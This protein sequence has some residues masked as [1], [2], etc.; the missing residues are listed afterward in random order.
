MVPPVPAAFSM[1]SQRSS[2][3]SS[4]SSRSAGSTT[5]TASSNPSPRWEPTW[6]TTASEPIASAVSIVARSAAS[7]FVAHDRVAAREIHEVEGV[8]GHAFTR[9]WRRLFRNRAISSGV[10]SV[11]RHIRGLWV[12]TWTAF[13]PISSTRSI[14]FEIP[15]AAET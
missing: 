6:K 13:P 14:A 1:H 5:S 4:R 11:G 12:K 2:V 3:V 8:T 10:C 9:A 7:E 15:P